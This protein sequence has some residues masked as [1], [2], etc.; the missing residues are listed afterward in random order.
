MYLGLSPQQLAEQD[1]LTNLRQ[2]ANISP[3]LREKLCKIINGGL[4]N[5]G[6]N[7]DTNKKKTPM[8]NRKTV[9]VKPQT[10]FTSAS[11]DEYTIFDTKET[12]QQADDRTNKVTEIINQ[13]SS[14][15]VEN[16]GAKLADFNPPPKPSIQMK[17]D[18]QTGWVQPDAPIPNHE[19]PLQIPAPSFTNTSVNPYII[20]NA[21]A[22]T[23][24]NY[25]KVYDPKNVE[26]KPYYGKMGISNG[27]DSPVLG[28]SKLMEK[29]NY[30]VHLLEN[31]DNEKTANI[32]EE[33]VLY[34]FLGVFII[35]VLDSFSK[36]GKYV[37]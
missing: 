17:K 26:Y 33:F 24:G 4:I 16:D 10:E 23:L 30:M 9:K 29:I 15:S 32:T 18:V 20:N 7:D 6:K 22:V 19:N 37:R 2:N 35:F 13:M 5:T 21:N 31:Q 28:D 25:Q 1:C 27:S 14:L 36:H 34:T 3:G 8:M 12:Q 11:I